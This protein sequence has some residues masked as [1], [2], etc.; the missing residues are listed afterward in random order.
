[1]V[2]CTGVLAQWLTKQGKAGGMDGSWLGSSGNSA[3]SSHGFPLSLGAQSINALSVD[4]GTFIHSF[5]NNCQALCAG[6][7]EMSEKCTVPTLKGV[8]S[9]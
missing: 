5:S 7:T 1:M 9:H 4:S 2:S 6:D 8:L 3:Q